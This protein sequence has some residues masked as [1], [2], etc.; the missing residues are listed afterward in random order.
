MK[1]GGGIW[2]LHAAQVQLS[3]LPR[4][5]KTLSWMETVRIRKSLHWKIPC[6]AGIAS[7]ARWHSFPTFFSAGS[8]LTTTPRP[9]PQ[10][11][12]KEDQRACSSVPWS[13]SNSITI[14][15]RN[16]VPPLEGAPRIGS[17]VAGAFPVPVSVAGT[18]VDRLVASQIQGRQSSGGCLASLP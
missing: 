11:R 15:R 17:Y 3:S 4:A 2:H 13:Q 12:S 7:C 14:A 16:G 6:I 5:F 1:A 9:N 10:G 8:A 18:L